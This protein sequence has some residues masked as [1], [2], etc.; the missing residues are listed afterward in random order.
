MNRRVAH[1]T[2]EA[3]VAFLLALGLAACG[4]GGGIGGFGASGSPPGGGGGGTIG[5]GGTGGGAGTQNATFVLFVEDQA[6]DNVLSFELTVTGVTLVSSTGSEVSLLSAP[7]EYE[8]R[9][10]T[11]APTVTSITSVPTGTYTRLRVTV[12]SPQMVVFNPV[13]GSVDA[14]RNP[15]LTTSTVTITI[16]VTLTANQF[17]GARLDLDLLN[18]IVS[19]SQVTPAFAFIPTSFNVGE[20]PGDIDDALGTVASVTTSSGRF[21]MTVNPG[22]AS[23]TVRTDTNT[24]FEGISGLSALQTGNEIEV[25]AR[26]QSDG[27]FLAST[28]EVENQSNEDQ[29][30]GL[31]LSRTPATGNTTSISLLVLE[32]NPSLSG[33]DAGDIVTVNIDPGTRFRINQEEFDLASDIRFSGLVFDQTTIEPGQIVAVEIE[34]GTAP[35]PFLADRI[36][37]KEA[38]VIG[39]VVSVGINRFTLDPVSDF[40]TP[41]NLGS[42]LCPVTNNITEFEDLPQGIVS[43]QENQTVSVR[44]LVFP[45]PPNPFPSTIV[46]K[47]VRLLAPP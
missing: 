4:A 36:A 13:S 46:T 10:R 12:A 3:G 42:I 26:L 5:G 47:R 9:S 7:V 2:L 16:N 33:I 39:R 43:M 45:A 21:T 31:V 18:S 15:S 8:W 27:T 19:N 29:L 25:D 22:G 28:V 30:R 44:G 14:E 34:S 20:L 1:D 41:I 17:F 37:L 11:L 40:Y 32:E 24:I 23:I 6:A 38:T 35:G